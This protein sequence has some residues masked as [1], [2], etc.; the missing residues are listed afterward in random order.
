MSQLLSGP[1][2]T[3][4][5]SLTFA[6]AGA[7]GL[8]IYC[9]SLAEQSMTEEDLAKLFDGL[10]EQC[11]VLLEDVDAAGLAV[12]GKLSKAGRLQTPL[13]QHLNDDIEND[14]LSFIEDV[15]MESSRGGGSGTVPG[16]SRISLSGLLNVIDGVA[17]SEG[18]LLVMT[19]NDIEHIDEALMRPGRIDLKINFELA[20]RHDAT[21]LFRQIFRSTTSTDNILDDDKKRKA[22]A[23]LENIDKLAAKFASFV[24]PGVL[25]QAEIQGYLM[26]NK[27]LPERA[28]GNAEKWISKRLGIA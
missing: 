20:T 4:K 15:H 18:R 5:T 27:D 2:G 10:P 16:I 8:D 12:R 23:D 26:T 17:A 3:G 25:G 24:P 21:L 22:S 13:E 7:F 11:L 9:I 19:T 1:P 14:E 6:L 28:V